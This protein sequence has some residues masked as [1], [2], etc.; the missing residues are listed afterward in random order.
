M[1]IA[2]SAAGSEV[3]APA[4]ERFGRCAYFLVFNEQGELQEVIDNQGSASAGG[5]GIRTTQLLLSNK[6]DVVLTGRVGPN[7]MSALSSGGMA[8]YAGV[9]GTVAETMEKYKDGQLE[10]LALPNAQEHSGIK[11]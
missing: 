11:S 2:V 3:S 10:P 7:A 4:E 9:S 6:I 5:A 8:V 1:R